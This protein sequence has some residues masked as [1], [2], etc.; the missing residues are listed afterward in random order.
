MKI[1]KCFNCA[2]FNGVKGRFGCS[3]FTECLL[4][5]PPDKL[6]TKI[7]DGEEWHSVILLPYVRFQPAKKY[8]NLPNELFEI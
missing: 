2:Y 8:C 7:F 4:S 1:I 6:I 5:P 3:C